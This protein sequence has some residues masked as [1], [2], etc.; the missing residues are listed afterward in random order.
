MTITNMCPMDRTETADWLRE[1]DVYA[2]FSLR[3]G[4]ETKGDPGNVFILASR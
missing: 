2:N 1:N 3:R 4:T